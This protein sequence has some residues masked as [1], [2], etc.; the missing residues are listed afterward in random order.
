[1]ATAVMDQQ[2]SE[3]PTKKH[4]FTYIE[5][6]VSKPTWKEILLE[7]I[8]SNRIDPWNIDIVEIANAFLEKVKEMER[9][10]FI[11][12]ANVILAA[13][14]LLRHKSNYLGTLR[15]SEIPEYMPEEEIP[16]DS[17]IEDVPQLSLSSRIPPK[18]QITL[19]ELVE[20]MERIIKY[21]QMETIVKKPRGSII[22]TVDLELEEE[23]IEK[24]M[25]EVLEKI[26]Q[27]TDQEGWSLFSKIIDKK[28][29]VELV[30]TLLSVLHLTQSNVIDIKQ[31]ELFGEIFIQ[32][33]EK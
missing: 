13:A 4:G 27:N 24:K 22:E 21:D 2:I 29:N 12:Q 28:D 10:D 5:E 23:D 17:A 7:L 8:D 30:Y 32:L 14:I 18:R 15:Q 31:D 33:L 16:L 19:D 25:K 20:E 1:M 26:K 6:M 3:K 9:M 11:I